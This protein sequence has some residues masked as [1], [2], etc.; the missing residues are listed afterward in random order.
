MHRYAAA[1]VQTAGCGKPVLLIHGFGAS[2]GHFRK[3]IP[4]LCAAGYKARRQI[5]LFSDLH[6][7]P[8]R[9]PS[10][11]TS[12]CSFVA[13]EF[14]KM[15]KPTCCSAGSSARSEHSY[16]AFCACPRSMRSICWPSVRQPSPS[17]STQWS[18]GRTWSWTFWRSSWR[19]PL[20]WSATHSAAS[21]P[22]LCVYAMY[23]SSH[24]TLT[25]LF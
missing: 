13:D 10:P 21:S 5:S 19:A 4:A 15:R 8:H 16:C 9:A 6:P 24:V 3:N 1:R 11:A 2:L 25:L 14:A 20:C 23:Q 12:C 17:W 22:S 18:C 7:R